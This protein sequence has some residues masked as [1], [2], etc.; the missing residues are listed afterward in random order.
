M[1]LFLEYAITDFFLFQYLSNYGSI[2]T[3]NESEPPSSSLSSQFNV[4]DFPIGSAAV[5]SFSFLE[6]N[7]LVATPFFH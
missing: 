7:L 1:F 5:H 4:S 3:L 6:P 2:T